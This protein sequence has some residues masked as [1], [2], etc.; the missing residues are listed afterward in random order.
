MLFMATVVSNAKYNCFVTIR[1]W[2]TL[3][4]IK[5]NNISGKNCYCKCIIKTVLLSN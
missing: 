1:I 3:K 5:D 4:T 2:Q